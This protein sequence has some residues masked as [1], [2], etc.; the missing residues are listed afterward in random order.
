MGPFFGVTIDAIAS[1]DA[2][3]MQ[4]LSALRH[5]DHLLR[6]FGAAELIRLDTG[7]EPTLRLREA[8]DEIWILYSGAALL[9]MKDV[10]PQ[11]PTLGEIQDMEI[12]A[13]TRVLIPFGVAA[14]WRPTESPV[15]LLRL[16]THGDSESP[17]QTLEWNTA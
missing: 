17:V 13:P 11:S 7:F 8:A 14:G 9:R 5:Q 6:R 15:R 3:Q 2:P 1:E 16:S 10:R 4:R 12:T